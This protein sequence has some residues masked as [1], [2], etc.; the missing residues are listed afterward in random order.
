MKH[1]IEIDLHEAKKSIDDICIL[2]AIV[3]DE[4]AKKYLQ[5]L[6]NYLQKIWDA[7]LVKQHEHNQIKNGDS[8]K[9][10]ESSTVVHHNI[11]I[12]ETSVYSS[13]GKLLFDKEGT[14]KVNV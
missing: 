5:S 3:K 9:F 10:N 12:D 11:S 14:V 4:D 1:Q 2:G 6:N 13:D 7:V 8:V